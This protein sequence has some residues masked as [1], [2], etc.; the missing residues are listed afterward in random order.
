[1]S[2]ERIGIQKVGEG[3]VYILLESAHGPWLGLYRV[4][5]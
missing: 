2:D 1:M 3:S 5:M 4:F